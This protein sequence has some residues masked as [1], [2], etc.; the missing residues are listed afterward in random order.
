MYVTEETAPGANFRSDGGWAESAH[1][2][3]DLKFANEYYFIVSRFS[4]DDGGRSIRTTAL[5]LHVW[6]R[7]FML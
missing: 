4:A 6:R 1:P 7:R 2:P 3:S 5:L